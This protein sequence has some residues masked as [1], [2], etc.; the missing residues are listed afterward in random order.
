[1]ALRTGGLTGDNGVLARKTEFETIRA[2]AEYSDAMIQAG[3]NALAGA[4]TRFDDA[5]FALTN[6]PAP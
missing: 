2:F 6:N 5:E 3:S 1:M 4:M